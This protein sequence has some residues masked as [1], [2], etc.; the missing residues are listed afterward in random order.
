[1][2]YAPRHYFATISAAVLLTGICLAAP[3]PHG[4][5]QQRTAQAAPAES[6]PADAREVLAAYQ[7]EETKA[8]QELE[9]K[10]APKRHELI[11]QLRALQD[12]YTKAGALDEAVAIRDLIRQWATGSEPEL[13]IANPGNLTAYRDRVGQT[14]YF[15]IVGV[16]GSSVWGTDVYTDDSPLAVA[17]VHSGVVKAGEKAVVRVTVLGPKD[18]YDGSSRNGIS[19]S[20]YGSWVGSYKV[21][22]AAN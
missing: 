22:P 3:G 2:T 21:Q 9:A 7:A 11:M 13:P 5:V 1:M 15:E 16:S 18:T 17:A 10:L 20:A 14:F 4:P 8:R 6:L 12:R 19:S